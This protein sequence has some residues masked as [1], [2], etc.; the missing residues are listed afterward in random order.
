[1][2]SDEPEHI[3]YRATIV[4]LAAKDRL[5]QFIHRASMSKLAG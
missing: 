2:M 5:P 4:Q 1:M 3:A